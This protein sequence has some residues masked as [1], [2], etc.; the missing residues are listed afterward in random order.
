MIDVVER[1]RSKKIQSMSSAKLEDLY[2]SQQVAVARDVEVLRFPE[3]GASYET[4]KRAIDL[5]LILISLP[6]LLPLAVFVAFA[7]RLESRGPILFRQARVGR[8]GKPFVMLKFR[9]MVRDSEKNGAQFASLK[10]PR[11]TRVGAFLRRTRLD[12]IPQLW[13]VLLGEMSLVG[14][15][16]EQVHF[17]RR[18]EQEIPDYV[19]RHLA[20]P[21]IT[22]W[23]Q[24]HGGYAFDVKTTRKKLRYDLF[25]IERRSTLLDVQILLKTIRI[26]LT[27]RGHR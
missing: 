17:V 9:S 2:L 23:A 13:N 6:I 3:T 22:G 11:I 15:R 25:Y 14:P 12:E 27:G 10:D 18:F 21:G 8:F 26:V 1:I 4:I 7:I 24:I 5:F 19:S 16:P 20:L